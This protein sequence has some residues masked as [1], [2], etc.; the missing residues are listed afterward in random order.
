MYYHKRHQLSFLWASVRDPASRA[1]SR[2]GYTLSERRP[3]E[4]QNESV[5]LKALTDPDLH[6]GT[7]SEGR[8]GFQ[9]QYSMLTIIDEYSAWNSSNPTSIIDPSMIK[10]HVAQVVDRYDFLAVAE[11]LDESLVALQLL[12]GLETYDIL[13][14]ATKMDYERKSVRYK[15]KTFQCVKLQRVNVTGQV[16]DFLE[17][18]EW[19]A[20]N[21]GDYLLYT[22]ANQSLDKTI[23]GLGRPKFDAA[24]AHY[25]SLQK[26]AHDVCSPQVFF[27]CSSNGTDQYHLSKHNCYVM[28]EGCGYPCFD[29]MYL[30]ASSLQA[31]NE[32]EKPPN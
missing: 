1:I 4:L 17:S 15:K 27:P 8:G 3:H 2:V 9:L 12:L 32:S 10:K 28:E 13:H 20:R 22:A 31:N 21:Y 25:R 14:F 26:Q 5:I 16:G 7:V 6:Y 23:L 29:D 19:F 30:K 24:L 18:T 11:R